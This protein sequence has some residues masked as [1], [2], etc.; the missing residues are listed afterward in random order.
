MSLS[1]LS[2]TGQG[3]A[4][5]TSPV[6]GA[7]TLAHSTTSHPHPTHNTSAAVLKNISRSRTHQWTGRAT[8]WN[9]A[10]HPHP[11]HKTNTLA[12]VS[13]S[14]QGQEG[15]TN[16]LALLIDTDSLLKL[17]V[18]LLLSCDGQW[19]LLLLLLLAS[20]YIKHS[21]T[22]LSNARFIRVALTAFFLLHS[23]TTIRYDTIREKSFMWTEKL[24]VICLIQHTKPER[25][26]QK[27]KKKQLKQTNTSA[28]CLKA[29]TMNNSTIRFCFTDNVFIGW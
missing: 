5:L 20:R 25:K 23:T 26:K 21:S 24:S 18:S 22:I 7:E 4:L 1:D 8:C 9:S 2:H 14:C 10:S 3:V 12:V 28:H 15:H 13:R 6:V 17:Q 29:V 11:T 19:L 16:E 27:Y